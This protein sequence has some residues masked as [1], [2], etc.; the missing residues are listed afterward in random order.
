M[1]RYINGYIRCSPGAQGLFDSVKNSF[2]EGEEDRKARSEVQNSAHHQP[3]QRRGCAGKCH[4]PYAY[5]GP[6]QPGIDRQT[7]AEIFCSLVAISFSC[8]LFR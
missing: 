2:F 8:I 6:G 7:K 3:H 1:R 4:L 5:D